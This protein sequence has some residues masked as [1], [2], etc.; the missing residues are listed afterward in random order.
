MSELAVGVIGGG[1]MGISLVQALVAAGIDTVLTDNDPDVLAGVPDRLS[2]AGRF[3]RLSAS[4]AATKPGR[5]ELTQD[6]A[7][8]KACDLVIEN[9]VESQEV[10]AEVHQRLDAVLG[11]RAVVAVNTSAVPSTDLALRTSHPE[12]MVGAHF[13]NPVATSSMV[14]V[15]RT[16]YTASWALER[17]DRVLDLL[18]KKSVVVADAAGFVINRCLMM[19]IS[20]AAALLD[21]QVATPQQVDRLF[22]GCLGHRTGPLRTADI[23]GIDTIV[24]TLD[25]LSAHYG[26][27]RFTAAPRLRHMVAEGQLG[28]KTGHGFYDY[29]DGETA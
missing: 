26:P 5:L 13:M 21:D 28:L 18:G 17:L 11:E 7:V 22:R 8:L 2:A 14:E 10:K 6:V 16:S 23:I 3:A 29:S 15:V 24:H 1:V 19:F 25:V 27:E 20:E 4:Q 12:R 9:V